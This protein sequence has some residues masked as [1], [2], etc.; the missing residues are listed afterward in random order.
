MTLQ[1][2]GETL[3]IMKNKSAD[4]FVVVPYEKISKEALNGL[5]DEFILR[6]GTDYGQKEY[7][8][9]EKHQQ[10]NKQLLS[11]KII[12]VFDSEEQSASIIKKNS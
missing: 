3:L 12:I 6:E 9:E 11:G 8:L 4:D 10:I 7:T 5:I 1:Q 2:K